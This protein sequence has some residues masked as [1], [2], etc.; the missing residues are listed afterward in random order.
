MVRGASATATACQATLLRDRGELRVTKKCFDVVLQEP[1]RS[2]SKS[3]AGSLGLQ[4]KR[5]ARAASSRCTPRL[6]VSGIAKWAPPGTARPE[7][8]AARWNRDQVRKMQPGNAVLPGDIITA[9]NDET[10]DVAILRQLAP[11]PTGAER[12]MKIKLERQLE[13]VLTVSN[14]TPRGKNWSSIAV[15]SAASSYVSSRAVSSAQD[16]AEKS[17]CQTIC[18]SSV[19]TRAT[20]PSSWRQINARSRAGECSS[21]LSWNTCFSID[22]P[23]RNAECGCADGASS[24]STRAPSPYIDDDD[25]DSSSL[26]SYKL[27]GDFALPLCLPGRES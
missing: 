27:C 1:S 22:V 18:G 24:A 13:D 2:V 15:A 5:T 11:P 12:S 9:V 7:T 4:L 19:S 17:S 16:A 6:L 23:I 21:S 10:N 25:N 3:S 8:P 14:A 20:T 26:H